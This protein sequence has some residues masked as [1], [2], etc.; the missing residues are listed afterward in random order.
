MD[1]ADETLGRRRATTLD[2][3]VSWLGYAVFGSFLV[4]AAL[5][6]VDLWEYVWPWLILAGVSVGGWVA[7]GLGLRGWHGG[8]THAWFGGHVHGP[9]ARAFALV[10][11]VLGSV[12]VAMSLYAATYVL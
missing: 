5:F 8:Y 6:A 9:V 4:T 3:V 1:D 12:F 2:A 10:F 7:L 11:M